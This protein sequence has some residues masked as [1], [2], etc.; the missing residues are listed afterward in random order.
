MRLLDG[1][2]EC[3]HCGAVLNLPMLAE[4]Q[5]VFRAASGKANVRA[6]YV[7]GQEIHS[8]EVPLPGTEL[9]DQPSA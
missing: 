5:I 3:A 1:R 2:Y 8:C 6:L 7:D 9:G 4:P